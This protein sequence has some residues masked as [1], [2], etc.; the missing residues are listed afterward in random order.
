MATTVKTEQ[1]V[2]GLMM[3]LVAY[4]VTS[5]GTTTVTIKAEGLR[6]VEWAT[7]QV[8]DSGNRVATSDADVTWSGD[9]ITVADGGSFSL[10]D[11]QTLLILAAGVPRA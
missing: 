1:R 8:L 11:T 9:E 7:V 2:V 5:P 10:A 3:P 6:E 4:K